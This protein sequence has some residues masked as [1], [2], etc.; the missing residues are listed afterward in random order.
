MRFSFRRASVGGQ[1]PPEELALEAHGFRGPPVPRGYQIPLLRG[2]SSSLHRGKVLLAATG[3]LVAVLLVLQLSCG[4]SSCGGTPV[5]LAV[6]LGLLLVTTALLF[7]FWASVPPE[8]E[9]ARHRSDLGGFA[10]GESTYPS[11]D[12]IFD[13]AYG[14][15][16]PR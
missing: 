4:S 5:R 14:R 9:N 11:R 7:W 16:P 2:G 8:I 13:P 10:A 6:V 12:A 3:G 1:A 15:S